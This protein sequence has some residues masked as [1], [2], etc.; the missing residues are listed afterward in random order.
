[1]NYFE[2]SLKAHERYKG[3]LSVVSKMKIENK[4][5]LSIAYTPGV[6]QPCIEIH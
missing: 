3:K 5:D 6:A 2:E 4:D 1:M